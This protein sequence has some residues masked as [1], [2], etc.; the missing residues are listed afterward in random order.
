MQQSYWDLSSIVCESFKLP[1]HFKIDAPGL[2][3]LAGQGEDDPSLI[4][5]GTRLELPFWMAEYLTLHDFID[6][7]FPRPYAARVRNA[8][9]ADARS[10]QLRGLGAWWYAVGARL[11]GLSAESSELKELLSKTYTLRLPPIFSAAQ[12]LAAAGRVAATHGEPAGSAT[13][14]GGADSAG[15]GANGATTD[16]DAP[17]FGSG[18]GVGMGEEMVNFLKGLEEGE[19]ELLAI[20]QEAARIMRLYLAGR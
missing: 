5:L 11:G 2:G 6:I 19:R 18:A 12:H 20:G 15:G 10:V 9:A 17:G 1:C 4:R 13:G 16:P 8:L 14:S 3:H 7:S